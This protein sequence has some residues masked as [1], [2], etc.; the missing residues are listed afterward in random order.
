MYSLCTKME[1]KTQ[2]VPH[3]LCGDKTI[4]QNEWIHSDFLIHS[5]AASHDSRERWNYRE[6]S[7]GF[8]IIILNILIRNRI[9]IANNCS[10]VWLNIHYTTFLR[11]ISILSFDIIDAIFLLF[12]VCR[13]Y[14]CFHIVLNKSRALTFTIGYKSQVLFSYSGYFHECGF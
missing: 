5:D 13:E 12:E 4:T 14:I 2:A 10:N 7:W 3:E 9:L 1:N 8:D 6:L 11:T